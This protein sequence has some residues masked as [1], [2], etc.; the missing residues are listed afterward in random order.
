MPEFW[1]IDILRL[2]N[3][4]ETILILDLVTS[5]DKASHASGVAS[6]DSLMASVLINLIQ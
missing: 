1:F 4:N 2:T 6:L 3:S 5:V